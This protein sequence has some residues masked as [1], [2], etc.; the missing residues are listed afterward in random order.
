MRRL[1]YLTD[2]AHCVQAVADDLPN[3]GLSDWHFHVI[4]NDENSRR[5]HQIH[6]ESSL[7]Q[8]DIVHA[9]ERGALIGLASGVG[10]VLATVLFLPILESVG[11]LAYT[12]IIFLCTMFGAWSGGMFGMHDENHKI[13]RF[14]KDIESGK[15]LIMLDVRRKQVAK[16]KVAM[17]HHVDA[18]AAGADASLS[19]P[20]AKG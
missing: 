4:N 14:H 13:R 8:R 2:N 16:V 3:W 17:Q 15:H 6:S 1:Y 11:Q 12:A 18:H 10:A 5:K 20:I 19:D 7:Q 9:G